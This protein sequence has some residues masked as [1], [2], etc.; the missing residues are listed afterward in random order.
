MVIFH[1]YV[2]LPEGTTSLTHRVAAKP[3]SSHEPISPGSCSSWYFQ[4]HSWPVPTSQDRGKV[5]CVM[6]NQDLVL[7]SRIDQGIHGEVAICNST[8]PAFQCQV[9]QLRCS[10]FIWR[11]GNGEKVSW[12]ICLL[13]VIRLCD[14][15][16]IL[17]GILSAGLVQG[18][19]PT[20]Q[21]S[22]AS[23]ILNPRAWRPASERRSF[24][25]PQQWLAKSPF[26]TSFIFIVYVFDW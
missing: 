2:S 10:M 5:Y 7:W 11:L 15:G 1:S 12:G 22:D 25:A 6:H 8:W 24:H 26:P 19:N 14:E 18:G 21:R 9:N 17:P 23:Y 13:D 16:F 4:Y 20:L 3:N